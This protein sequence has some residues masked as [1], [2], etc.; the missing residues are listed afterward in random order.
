MRLDRR[1]VLAGIL[2]LA[3]LLASVDVHAEQKALRVGI[4]S[5]EDEDVWAVVAQ[6]A[7]QKGLD[8][9]L[10][11]FNDYT[12]PN[13]ALEDGELD[14]NAFQH[15][16]YLD[17]QIETRGYHIVPV[18]FTAV[19]PIGLYSK[20]HH[21]VAD[22]PADA[23]IGVP[24]D[25]SNEGRALRVLESQGLIKLKPEAGILATTQDIADNPKKLVV[26]ELDAGIVGR[27]IDDLD[28][29]VVNTDW[30]LKA[31]LTPNDRL[32]QIPLKK[33]EVWR[34]FGRAGISR[35]SDW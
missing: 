19:W 3:P 9:K 35:L 34:G 1:F 15:K 13:E 7:K 22:L 5:A 30:A 27:S 31:G 32:A 29:A 24:N 14:A 28:A 20:K 2:A 6:Q 26:K 10:V 8:V 33:S 4:M 21:T 17:N 23:V 16:P 12:Q 25:P 18:G 11:V